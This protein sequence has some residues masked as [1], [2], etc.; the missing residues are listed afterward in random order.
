MKLDINRVRIIRR[1]STLDVHHM[2]LSRM[3][4]DVTIFSEN[5]DPEGERELRKAM[6]ET[7]GTLER[8]IDRLKQMMV[9]ERH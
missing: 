8:H 4:E 9:Q 5:D 1:V 6:A 7:I 2:T 3:V